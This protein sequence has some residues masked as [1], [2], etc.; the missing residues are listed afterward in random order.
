M[1]KSHCSIALPVTTTCELNKALEVS[2]KAPISNLSYGIAFG[3]SVVSLTDSKPESRLLQ[4]LDAVDSNPT[5]GRAEGP[6]LD[7]GLS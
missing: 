1:S 6:N 3:S 7:L 5:E 4:G 2:A